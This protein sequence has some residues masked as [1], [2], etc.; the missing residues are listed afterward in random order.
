MLIKELEN[1]SLDDIAMSCPAADSLQEVL[2]FRAGSDT[3]PRQ[4][5]IVCLYTPQTFDA[6]S[7][8]SEDEGFEAGDIVKQ[9]ARGAS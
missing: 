4:T 5:F 9:L 8:G 3:P 6:L 7:A 1:Q 2:D